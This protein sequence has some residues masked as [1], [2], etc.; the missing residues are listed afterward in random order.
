[1]GILL[2]NIVAFGLP[3]AAYFS[4]LAWGGSTGANRVAWFLN[5]WLVEGRLRGLFSFLFGAS[6]LLVIERAEAN[7]DA[8]GPVHLSRMFWLFAIG[9]VHLYLFWWGDILTH[10]A[11]VGTVAFVFHRLGAR[12][13]ALMALAFLTLS[14]LL[15]AGGATALFASTARSTAAERAVW[16]GF[17]YGFGVPP[18]SHLTAEIA[19]MRGGFWQAAGWRWDTALNPL[20]LLQFLGP[21]TLSAV[22]LGM[23]AYRS[24]FVTGGWSARA[25][26]GVAIVGIGAATLGYGAMGIAT[27][28]H[29]FDLRFVYVGVNLVAVPFRIAGTLGYAALLVLLLRD[30]GAATARL[31]A[32]GRM[33]FSNYL[34]TTLLMDIVFCG[35]GLGQFARWERATLYL[36]VPAVWALML[37]WS[38]WWLRRFAYGPFEWLWRSLARAEI[39]PL[40]RAA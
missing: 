26:C 33:A 15:G 38:P 16:D 28:A 13:L 4:P 25:Y 29:G 32:V 14:L 27:M 9:C 22:L 37:W 2:A 17:S 7:G 12:M 10:Y 31:A 24:G 23:A 8:P 34:G 30:G 21:E 18:A 3:E 39:Q 36:L 1:M 11:L 5:Y 20:L 35:W 40:R 6:M 19:A